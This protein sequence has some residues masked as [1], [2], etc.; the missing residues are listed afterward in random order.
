MSFQVPQ[1]L[2]MMWS[3]PLGEMCQS[4]LEE[5]Q[6]RLISLPHVKI[7]TFE[8]FLIWIYAY[9]P[10]LDL[11]NLASILDLA[12][13]AEMYIIYQLKNQTSDIL[14]TEL[15]SGRWQL[16]PDDVSL[17][18]D[19]VPS[20]SI[21]RKLCFV[22]FALPLNN[23]SPLGFG[24]P[25]NFVSFANAASAYRQHN[26][27]L[28]WESAFE[29]NSGLGWDYFRQMQTGHAQN[30]INCGGPCRF[31]DH[32]D[33]PGVRRED[34]DKCPYPRG[35]LPTERRTRSLPNEYQ[36][37]VSVNG[38]NVEEEA[39]PAVEETIVEEPTSDPAVEETT[40]DE[41]ALDP[42]V[43]EAIV[44]EPIV[45]EAVQDVPFWE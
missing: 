33:I 14:R 9:E 31:H 21:L 45:E 3:P 1:D 13:F 2:L 5:S 25:S 32:R 28:E 34:I 15:S 11:K 24:H 19:E 12:I 41:P 18:Y 42:A 7:S 38:N 37:K 35:A 16:T 26:N 8:N 6:T 29:K 22:S 23:P 44:E 43:E 20:G 40:V 27:Y 10:S 39:Q 4:G 36:R 17:V 30:T